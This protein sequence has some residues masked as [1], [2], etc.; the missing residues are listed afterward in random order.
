MGKDLLT[1][2]EK[3]FNVTKVEGVATVAYEDKDVYYQNDDELT[4]ATIDKVNKHNN[5]YIASVATAAKEQSISIMKEDS[6]IEK[7]I[8]ELPY[9]TSTKGSVEVAAKRSHTYKGMNG[10]PD[11]TKS[12]MKVVVTDPL[13]KLGK[14]AIKAHEAE[15]TEALIA[16]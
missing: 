15:M 4:K 9:G 14:T 12:T 5:N 2:D 6:S 10:G 8:V 11:V 1:F 3:K 13:S 16:G 7:V